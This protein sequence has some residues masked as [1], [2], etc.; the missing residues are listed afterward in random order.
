MSA[1]LDLDGD[2]LI[3]L[4]VGAQGSAVLLRWVEAE[5][6]RER[7]ALPEQILFYSC[8]HWEIM[9]LDNTLNASPITSES[10]H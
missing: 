2:E 4:A 7:R 8:K 9:K 5:L 10:P 1:R 6:G 3:D